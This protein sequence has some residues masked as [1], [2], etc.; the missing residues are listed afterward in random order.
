[1]FSHDRV[2]KF[3][4]KLV[5]WIVLFSKNLYWIP[6]T[7]WLSLN[8]NLESWKTK[9][10]SDLFLLKGCLLLFMMKQGSISSSNL[11]SSQSLIWVWTIVKSNSAPRTILLVFL[12]VVFTWVHHHFLWS[13]QYFCL[14]P[15]TYESVILEHLN[16]LVVEPIDDILIFSLLKIFILDIWH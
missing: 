5:L 13:D 16:K 10:L 7:S 3:M 1:M 12:L 2:V 6:C 4:S 8:N 15:T 14:V 9:A 11:L